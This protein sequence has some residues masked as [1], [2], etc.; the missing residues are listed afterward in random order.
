VVVAVITMPLELESLALTV[1]VVAVDLLTQQQEV[2]LLVKEMTEEELVQVVAHLLMALAVEVDQAVLVEPEVVQGGLALVEPEHQTTFLV[3]HCLTP[4]AGAVAITQ[5][6]L[7]VVVALVVM[8]V[9]G[10]QPHKLAQ[11]IVAVAVAVVVQARQAVAT[12]VLV[13]LF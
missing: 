9:L 8:E 7:L 10:Q 11:Q 2:E 6:L 3:R 13:L 1:P 5:A 4:A 12:E